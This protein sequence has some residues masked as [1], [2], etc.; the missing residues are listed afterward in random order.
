M[1]SSTLAPFT[2][3]GFPLYGAGVAGER[4]GKLFA[5]VGWVPMHA[6]VPDLGSLPVIVPLDGGAVAQAYSPEKGIVRFYPSAEL[7]ARAAQ[8]ADR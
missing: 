3:Q 4:S 5:V 7:A 2:P 1:S 6:N 8:G